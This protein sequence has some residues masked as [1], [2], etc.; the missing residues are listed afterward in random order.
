[1]LEEEERRRRRRVPDRQ[2]K[3]YGPVPGQRGGNEA[4]VPI[5]SQ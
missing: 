4:T 5:A 3:S 2:T 1:M